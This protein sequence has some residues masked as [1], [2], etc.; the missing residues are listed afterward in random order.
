MVPERVTHAVVP[1]AVIV[2]V[3]V[4]AA[5]HVIDSTTA[6]AVMVPAG[7]WGAVAVARH[8]GG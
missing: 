1:V 7:G 2:C 6:L 4:L 8:P 3:T 5:L